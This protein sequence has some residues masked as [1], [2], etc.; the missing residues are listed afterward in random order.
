MSIKFIP[1]SLKAEAE[2]LF[3]FFEEYV[4]T[5][6]GEIDLDSYFYTGEDTDQDIFVDRYIQF[7]FYFDSGNNEY[8]NH[9]V[10]LERLLDVV[11]EAKKRKT[12]DD[13][14]FIG[15]KVALIPIDSHDDSILKARYQAP[16]IVTQYIKNKK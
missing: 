10:S 11:S 4:I 14:K 13:Y 3:T 1:E 8:E 5:A 6:N 16:D 15:D 7:D 12:I 9:N 2:E